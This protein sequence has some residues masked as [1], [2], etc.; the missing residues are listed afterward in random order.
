[1]GGGKKSLEKEGNYREKNPEGCRQYRLKG[2]SPSALIEF[3]EFDERKNNFS[4][5]ADVMII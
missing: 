5:I 3:S 1:M 4:V 2:A